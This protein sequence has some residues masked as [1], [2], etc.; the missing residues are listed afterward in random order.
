M[1]RKQLLVF[2]D[3]AIAFYSLL[4]DIEEL[5][6]ALPPMIAWDFVIF[7]SWLLI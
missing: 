3:T 4:S 5:S 7:E 2:R 1:Q 6:S